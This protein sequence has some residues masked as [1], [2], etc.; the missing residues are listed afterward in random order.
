[1]NKT[2]KLIVVTGGSSGIG[3][4]TV[5]RLARDSAQIIIGDIDEARGQAVA[6]G[7]RDQ[8][9]KA[10]FV[11]VDLSNEVDISR[12]AENILQN[13]GIPDVLVNSAGLLQNAVHVL[14]M[15][16][17]EFDRL[18]AV[19]VRGTLLISRALAGPMCEAGRGCIVNLCSLTSFFPSAQVGYAT[20]KASLKMLTEIMA[21]DWGPNGVR[22]NAVAPGYTLT[23]A[24]QARINSGERDPDAVIAKTPLGRFVEPQEVAETIAFL[25]SPAAS[26]ITGATLPIDCGWLVGA[27]YRAF[28]S[29]PKV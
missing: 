16:I 10:T 24:M 2:S 22:V 26:A 5:Q 8:G 1:M 21:A 6:G 17:A 4:A 23:P 12:F 29:Q 7:L 3:E 13:H 9:C 20:G 27:A 19:N 11:R 14:D 15:D 28:A 25:C 18:H